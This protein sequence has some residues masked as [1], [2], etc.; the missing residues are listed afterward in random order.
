MTKQHLNAG[1]QWLEK[2]LQLSAIPTTVSIEQP[3]GSNQKN[4]WLTIDKQQLTSTQIDLLIGSQ[5]ATIDAIQY[6]A[7][8]SLNVERAEDS[9]TGY[10]VELNGYRHQRAIELKVVA[11]EAASLVRATGQE[12][13]L[14]AMSSAERRQIH[15]FFEL[16][17]D[18]SDLSTYSRGQEPDRRLVVK[19]LTAP[20]A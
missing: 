7:N 14:P 16:D 13:V 11:D 2:L 5:G 19:L 15:S 20:E 4:C 10:I 8:V 6:L 3:A 12:V 18:Y 1:K 17:E 9:Q